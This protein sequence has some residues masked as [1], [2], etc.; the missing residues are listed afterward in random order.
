MRVPLFVTWWKLSKS[1]DQLHI[2]KDR[3]EYI[4]LKT[5]IS[6]IWKAYFL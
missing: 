1:I 3:F 5:E 2:L 4:L 6:F